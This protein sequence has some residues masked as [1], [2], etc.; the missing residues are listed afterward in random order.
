MDI[1]E[2]EV[3]TSCNLEFHIF[4]QLQALINM[5]LSNIDSLQQLDKY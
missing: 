2:N 1:L 4:Y 3:E 5:S